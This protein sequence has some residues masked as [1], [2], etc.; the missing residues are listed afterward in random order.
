M[1][2]KVN[3]FWGFATDSLICTEK[4]NDSKVKGIIGG[5]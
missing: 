4:T 3:D 5:I 2:K 1:L